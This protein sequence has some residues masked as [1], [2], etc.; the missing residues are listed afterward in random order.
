ML[1][2]FV[3]IIGRGNSGTRII[4]KT[5][6]D[7][8]I[9]MG[10]ISNYKTTLF[11]GEEESTYDSMPHLPIYTAAKMVAAFLPAGFCVTV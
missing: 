2:P 9:S 10:K 11:D 7:S 8:G 3:I 4:S 5:L 1:E 6:H